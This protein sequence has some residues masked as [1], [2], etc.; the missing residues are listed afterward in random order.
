VVAALV[1]GDQGAIDRSD[2]D[3]FRATG[4]AHLMSISGLHI[5]LFAWVAMRVM[6][7]LW[8]RSQR[9]CLLAPAVT[10]AQCCGLALAT[11]Y[12][13]FSG[14][15]VPSQR[16]IWMLAVVLGLRLTGRRWP[17][18]CVWLLALATVLLFDPWA[19]LQAGFWLSFVA[20]GVLMAAD[21]GRAQ[22]VQAHAV[23]LH[24]ASASPWWGF[25]KNAATEQWTITLALAPLSLL[26]FH[27]VSVVGLLANAL[28]IPWVTLVVT[29]LAMLGVLLAPLWAVATWAVQALGWVLQAMAQWPGAVLSLPAAPWPLSALAVLGGVLLS[30]RLPWA[31]RV[32]ALPLMLPVVLYTVPRPAPGQFDLLAADVG[33]GTAVLVRTA[34]HSLL[35]DAGPRYGPDSDAGHR[36]LVPLLRAQGETLDVLM[37]SHSDIDHTGGAP[38]I[39]QMQ[40]QV[41]V[42]SSMAPPQGAADWKRCHAGQ[43]W[44]WEGVRFDVLHPLPSD[45]EAK[46]TPN[47]MSCV[48]KITGAGGSALLVGDIELAQEMRLLADWAH[49]P[50]VLRADVLL[51]PHHG[52]KTSSS[53]AWIDAVSPRVALVQ[54]GYRNRFGHPAPQVEQRYAQRGIKVVRSDRCGA[55]RGRSESAWIAPNQCEREVSRRY[56]NHTPEPD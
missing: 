49:A 53:P 32:L 48:L 12:A 29:P 26:L 2:W 14:W 3:T 47:A 7:W 38:A 34:G 17:W 37:L 31:L 19:M 21:P 43:S 33:Q 30:L 24:G 13:L 6:R 42:R 25:L 8:S 40:P 56:W 46:R 27:Q 54:A 41:P 20:V 51:V 45:Y 36:V 44:V 4:V 15:G 1:V 22:A 5:T 10:A 55:W 18:P 23:G 50:Q 16:T 39:R 9:L 11:L 28:A 52:S 35:Y